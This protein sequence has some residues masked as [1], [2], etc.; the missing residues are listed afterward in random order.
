MFPFTA[1]LAKPLSDEQK[2][3][4]RQPFNDSVKCRT[5]CL[6]EE[7]EETQEEQPPQGWVSPQ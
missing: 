7:E 3:Y 1:Q 2:K 5:D 4:P 6:E